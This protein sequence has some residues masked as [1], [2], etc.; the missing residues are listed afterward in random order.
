MKRPVCRGDEGQKES[1]VGPEF[2]FE[3]GYVLLH[4]PLACSCK[5]PAAMIGGSRKAR[6][7][8]IYTADAQIITKE[9]G[10]GLLVVGVRRHPPRAIHAV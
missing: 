9:G 6:L 3:S 4:S 8:Y 7:V 10:S 2:V 1:Y 5:V